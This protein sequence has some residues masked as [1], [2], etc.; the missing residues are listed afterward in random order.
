MSEKESPVIIPLYRIENPIHPSPRTPDGIVS[1][2][3]LVGQWFSPNLDTALRY[4]RKSSQ[5]FGPDSGPVDGTQLVVAHV[6]ESG[7]EA[8]H[9]S[10]NNTARGMDV[11]NDNYLVPRD[12][13]VDIDTIP[14]DETIGDLRGQLGKMDRFREAS[15]RIHAAIGAVAV[16]K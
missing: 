7:L 14:L 2:E 9:V 13:S 3:D 16:D 1:H 15:D 12:G 10:Q 8:L 11:E 6:P 4:L 5:T